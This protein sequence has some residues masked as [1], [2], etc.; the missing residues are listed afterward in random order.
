M[1]LLTLVG[2]FVAAGPADLVN[3]AVVLGFD[4]AVLYLCGFKA[5]IYLA[6]GT[7]MGGGM[8]PMAGHLISEHYMFIKVSSTASCRLS[9]SVCTHGDIKTPAVGAD[10][11]GPKANPAYHIL[12]LHG[13]VSWQTAGV[14]GGSRRAPLITA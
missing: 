6:L 11:T 2:A 3:I 14:Q 4:A 5:L 9:K 7:V 12:N 13:F 8:H 1:S 10:C